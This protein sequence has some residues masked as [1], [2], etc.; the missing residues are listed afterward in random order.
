MLYQSMPKAL[1]DPTTDPETHERLGHDRVDNGGSVT[2]RHKSR[3]HHIGV[4]RTYAGTCVTLLSH[5]LKI[6]VVEAATGEVL[7]KLTLA[8]NR[9]TSPPEHPKAPPADAHN[10]QH[11]DL[12]SQVRVSPMSC[13]ITRS[14]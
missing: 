8:P 14:G 1:P 9:A 11:P 5:D 7:R 6:K 3:L 13:D 4:G 2:L 10:E 12:H